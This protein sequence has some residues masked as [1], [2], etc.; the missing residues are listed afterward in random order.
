MAMFVIGAPILGTLWIFF[1]PVVSSI[2]LEK[3]EGVTKDEVR[4]IVGEP[5]EISDNQWLYSWWPNQGWVSI[6]FDG[7]GRVAV[8]NDEQVGIFR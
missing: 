7:N 6:S 8:V 1:G 3:L 5:E 4:R 2:K